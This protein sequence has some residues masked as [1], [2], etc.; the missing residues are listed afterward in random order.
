MTMTDH[1]IAERERI[2]RA[3]RR[4]YVLPELAEALGVELPALEAFT[5]GRA[6]LAPALLAAIANILARLPPP[7]PA[8]PAPRFSPRTNTMKLNAKA[9]KVTLVLDATELAALPDPTAARI[10]LQISVA[11]GRTVSADIA[12]KSLRKA[13]AT[14]AEHGPDN[15]AVVLQG[16][17]M[18]GNVV[19]EAGLVAQSKQPKAPN[20]EK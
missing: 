9:L 20:G 4:R 8:S 3:L 18:D 13:K 16:K 15:V 12:G 6:N 11:G 5:S 10:V 2:R 1:H 14:I 7:P 19:A 17:L